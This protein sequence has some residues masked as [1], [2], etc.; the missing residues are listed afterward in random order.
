MSRVPKIRARAYHSPTRQ[1]QADD[2]RQRIA[3][4]ARKLL[5]AEGFDGMTIEAVAREAGVAIQ[6][7][8]AIFGSKRGIV[9]ALMDRARFGPDYAELVSRAREETDPALRLRLTA[10]VARRIY[11]AER[12]EMDV[13]R[14]AGVVAP[15]LAAMDRER[16]R[17]RYDGQGSTIRL[18]VDQG[19]LRADLDAPAARDV[20]WALTGREPYR[21]LVIERE[22]S[23]DRY[24]RWLGELLQAALLTPAARRSGRKA[25]APSRTK[26]ARDR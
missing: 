21:L 7:V 26:R 1:R 10:G 5:I 13:L 20:L 14:A 11:D 4:A 19:R 17:E 9:A 2:T 25:V 15:E 16:E 6:T 18:M 22:W 24:E 23:S 3:H 12:G 8:Y